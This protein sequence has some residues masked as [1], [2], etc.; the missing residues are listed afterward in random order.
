LLRAEI[1][2]FGW[3]TAVSTSSQ[4]FAPEIEFTDDISSVYLKKKLKMVAFKFHGN[5][6]WA[7]RRNVVSGARAT[8]VIH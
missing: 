6:S 2:G 1:N 5:F 3:E 8:Y 7:R 4:S